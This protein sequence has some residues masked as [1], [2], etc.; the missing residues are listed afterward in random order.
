[1][2]GRDTRSMRLLLAAHVCS[3]QSGWLTL[4]CRQAQA[5]QETPCLRRE[6]GILGRGK[7]AL[8]LL[9]LGFCTWGSEY[10]SQTSCYLSALSHAV[11]GEDC[12]T[13]TQCLKSVQGL[14][15]WAQLSCLSVVHCLAVVPR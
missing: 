1:M 3:E 6:A 8:S 12:Y 7:A 10:L 5:S 14:N 15:C 2:P 11:G 13:T 9:D 4:R